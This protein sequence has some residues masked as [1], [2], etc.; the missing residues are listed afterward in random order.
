[1][2][3]NAVELWSLSHTLPIKLN[4]GLIQLFSRLQTWL[5]ASTPRVPGHQN[6]EKNLTHCEFLEEANRSI[7]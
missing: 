3:R 1:M 7:E 2:Y 6:L 4:G 5:K